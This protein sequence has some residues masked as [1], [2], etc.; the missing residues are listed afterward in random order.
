MLRF[1][2]ISSPKVSNSIE[3]VVVKLIKL[4]IVFNN[5][6]QLN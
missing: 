4:T 6:L 1:F 3:F 5:N 2:Y